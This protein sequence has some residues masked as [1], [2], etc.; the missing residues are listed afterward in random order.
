MAE[1]VKITITALDK[2]KAAFGNVTKSLKK[3]GGPIIKATKALAA[4]GIAAVTALTALTVSSLKTG[5][6]LAKTADKLGVTT[7]ALAGLRL[8]AEL[9]GV[10]T[11]TMDMAMQRLTRRVAEA[12]QGTGEAK[13]AIKE[14]GLNADELVKMPVDK[15]ME[16]IA[17]AMGNVETQADKV[18]L[19]MK[20]FDSEGVALVNT[21]A[22]GEEGLRQ[23]AAEAEALGLAMSRTDTA[24]IEAANDAVTR[25]AKVF[26]G[27]GNQLAV[28]FAP[29][30]ETV[31][32][33]FRQAALDTEGFGS[34]GQKVADALV[35]AFA[36]LR[37][38]LHALHIIVKQIQLG[39][40]TL[41][42]YVSE[43]LIPF[44]QDFVNAYNFVAEKLGKDTI[45]NGF[46]QF[47]IDARQ[48]VL[49]LRKEIEA[50]QDADP[51]AAI[52]QG[53]EEIK[54]QSRQTA[55][56]IA[57]VKAEA[58][59]VPSTPTVFDNIGDAIGK[60]T[61]SLP[62]LQES[63]QSFTK[64]AMNSFTQAFT[65]AITG[66]K[67]FGESMKNLAKS[68]VDS[69]VKMLVQYY[70]T[71]PLFEAI[72]GF[73]GDSEGGG[74]GATGKAIG[75]SVQAGQPYM[76]GERGPEMFV[77][78]QSGSIVA[79][80]K[81]GGGAGVVVNQTIN[82]TTGVQSTVRAEIAGL[83]PQIA[84]AAKGAV[85]DARVRGGNFSRAMVGA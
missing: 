47:A 15:Q 10:S 17:G 16:V 71:K 82:V 62:S 40:M 45:G 3:L 54:A 37:G 74:G 57:K 5:D 24:Q 83:M 64:G 55:E 72:K 66:A 9:S 30:I 67:S 23:M 85:A 8:A 32:N 20:L 81:M 29:I 7:E 19:S 38:G 59:E 12:A 61:D 22:L 78:N 26:K 14:L 21:L 69:L 1:N 51:A 42:A 11:Q 33:M 34:I 84:Q 43:S 60:A 44:I 73:F 35:S 4:M 50:M 18:R 53:Y 79:N 77:P 41:G 58:L 27:L 70:I 52:R 68:V 6:A 39:F 76:V 80:N 63:M 2:T 36:L 56:A 28:A 13:S 48:G 75:G 49:D 25:S 31:A 65:D 46:K